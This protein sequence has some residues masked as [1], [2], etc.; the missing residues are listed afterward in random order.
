MATHFIL[1][2]LMT[3]SGQLPRFR[4]LELDLAYALL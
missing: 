2:E 1:L 4:R 3:P